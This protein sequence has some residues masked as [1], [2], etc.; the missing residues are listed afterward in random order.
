M[1]IITG[2]CSDTCIRNFLHINA[3]NSNIYTGIYNTYL[4][5]NIFTL[6]CCIFTNLIGGI[7]FCTD[8]FFVQVFSYCVFIIHCLNK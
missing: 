4:S 2:V 3:Q 6:V 8:D 5:E 1:L 7:I